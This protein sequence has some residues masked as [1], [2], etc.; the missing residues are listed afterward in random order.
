MPMFSGRTLVEDCACTQAMPTLQ[1]YE[2]PV[3]HKVTQV[4]NVQ[5]IKLRMFVWF[6][7]WF[8]IFYFKFFFPLVAASLVV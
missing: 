4:L 5:K 1:Q 2:I 6:G 3:I 8:I 7:W